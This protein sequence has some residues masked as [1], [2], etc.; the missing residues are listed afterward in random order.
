MVNKHIDI[1]KYFTKLLVQT[2]TTNKFAQETWIIFNAQ[3]I[4]P[5]C[6]ASCG[7]WEWKGQKK[8][9]KLPTT[10]IG[11]SV[12]ISG[13]P[14]CF[15]ICTHTTSCRC[16]LT[17]PCSRNALWCLPAWVLFAWLISHQTAVL[18]SSEQTSHQ[19]PVSC[20]FLSKQTSTNHQPPAKRTGCK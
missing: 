6:L 18:F 12:F 4:R 20:T 13:C 8:E 9:K 16:L 1:P 5:K 2:S 15:N 3:V 11:A 7:G 19:Q 17:A 14:F 10:K